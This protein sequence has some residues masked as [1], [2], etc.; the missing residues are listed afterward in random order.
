MWAFLHLDIEDLNCKESYIVKGV[1]KALMP[2]P[3][4]LRGIVIKGE[5]KNHYRRLTLLPRVSLILNF[6]F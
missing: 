2:L 1:G 4:A 5:I 3:K 6:E